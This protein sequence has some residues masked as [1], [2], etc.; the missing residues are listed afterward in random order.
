MD[1]GLWWESWGIDREAYAFDVR[2]HCGGSGS[3]TSEGKFGL[4]GPFLLL[5][6]RGCMSRGG[7]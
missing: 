1:F 2:I 4:F 6:G 5:L 7:G 3:S